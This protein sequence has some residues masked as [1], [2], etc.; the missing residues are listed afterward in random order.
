[1]NIAEFRTGLDLLFDQNRISEVEPYLEGALKSAIGEQDDDAVIQ[2]LNEMI[3][4]YRE[5][6]D[7]DRA[8]MYGEKALAII[9]S[10]GAASTHAYATTKLNLANA[11]RAAGKLNEAL[12]YYRD[13][14]EIYSQI[15]PPIAFDYASLY[16]NMSLVYQEAQVYPE[17][18]SCLNAAMKI[19][20]EHP[21]KRFE[22]AVTHTNLGNSLIG[23]VRMDPG[24]EQNHP[25]IYDGIKEHLT[26]A[27]AIFK[28]R[29][30]EGAHL[31][32]AL[33]GLG[34]L[35]HICGQDGEA[36]GYYARALDAISNNLGHIEY[37][38]RVKESYDSVYDSVK[39]RISSGEDIRIPDEAANG[40]DLCRDYY[41]TCV[42]P[43]ITGQYPLLKD[44]ICAGLWG[45][46]SDAYGYDDLESRDHDWGPGVMLMIDDEELYKEHAESLRSSLIKLAE[47][48]ETFKGYAPDV[49]SI[50]RGRRGVFETRAYLKEKLG[51]SF[52]AYVLGE[53][54]HENSTKPHDEVS[55]DDNRKLLPESNNSGLYISVPEYILSSLTNGEIWTDPSGVMTKVRN[56]LKEYYPDD[57]KKSMLKQQCALF[58]QNAQ[59]NFLRMM[60]RQDPST[61]LMMLSDGMKCAARIIYILNSRYVPHD[62]WIMKGLD[63]ISDDAADIRA[64]ISG[65]M[66]EA[67]A[68]T[69]V[70]PT[71][72]NLR[73][74]LT[75]IDELSL[76]IQDMMAAAGIIQGKHPYM[77][78]VI[79]EM[80]KETLVKRV[81]KDEWEAFD[82]VKN[83]GG[84]AD[85]QDNFG[86]FNIMRSS[87]YLTWTP[88]MLMKYAEDFEANMKAGWNPITEKYGRMEESTAPDKYAEI[89]D[90]LP[91]VDERKRAIIEEIVSVQVGWMEDFASRYPKLAGNARSIHTS[92]DT[93]FD[94]SYETYLRGELMTYS[95][96]MLAMYGAF[97]VDIARSGRNLADMTMDNTVHLY[98]Y[99][100]L[101]DAEG[102]L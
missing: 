13:T 84:R 55:A 51:E 66:K 27:V 34:D 94:T 32:A 41:E 102:S 25:D 38:Y 58:S 49:S 74:I 88:E 18:I 46:G 19:V 47:E 61:A 2:I 3:G 80:D 65:I 29:G 95:D 14:E 4:F 11:L 52:A 16:N 48:T 56:R 35:Y 96:E 7:Y 21:E 28:E 59:Y 63:G 54:I 76:A 17:A 70:I 10:A 71:D 36:L 85:C 23:A 73:P 78:D 24:I 12:E 87:Q 67:S 69:D 26:T 44:H 97:I 37:Y 68:L 99:K 100:S 77:E 53:V 39:K 1:M 101:D 92:E 9:E 93:P 40:I 15:L 57:L 62:K 91:P 31:A 50:L 45:E 79:M 43:M 72:A 30:E 42:A 81:V 33:N 82:K 20:L 83:E 5:T 60:R 8:I 6:G 86:T 98:G 22:L 75:H 89:A 90:S 64:K